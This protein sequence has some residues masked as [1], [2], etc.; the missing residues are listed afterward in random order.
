MCLPSRS[1]N[2]SVATNLDYFTDSV[3]I[4]A[5]T[6]VSIASIVLVA[7]CATPATIANVGATAVLDDLTVMTVHTA[8]QLPRTN[9]STDDRLPTNILAQSFVS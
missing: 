4:A 9:H 5:S 2:V 3:T 6:T 8:S 7:F 1:P